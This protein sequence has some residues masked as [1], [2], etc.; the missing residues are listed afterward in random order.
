MRS[1]SQYA[2]L[3]RVCSFSRHGCDKAIARNGGPK[4]CI[5]QR[6]PLQDVLLEFLWRHICMGLHLHTESTLLLS[7][8]SITFESTHTSL[9]WHAT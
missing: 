8:Y 3:P 7:K 4:S 5:R 9:H 2:L 1:I 6:L